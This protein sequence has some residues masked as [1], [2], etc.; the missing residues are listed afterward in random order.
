MLR[1]LID[2]GSISFDRRMVLVDSVN[3]YHF[4]SAEAIL[5]FSSHCL[6]LRSMAAIENWDGV[7]VRHGG[8]LM[9]RARAVA[10]GRAERHRL[11]FRPLFRLPL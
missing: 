11:P 1:L 9:D 3:V 5:L 4:V 7:L 8:K 2:A 10:I 6:Y